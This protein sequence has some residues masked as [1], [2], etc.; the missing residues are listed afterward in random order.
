M[1]KKRT[2][3][4][5]FLERFQVTLAS[6]YFG[7]LYNRI[8]RPKNADPTDLITIYLK[9]RKWDYNEANKTVNASAFI[10]KPY[11]NRLETSVFNIKKMKEVQIWRLGHLWTVINPF[12]KNSGMK[13][14]KARGD[15][16]A[17]MVLKTATLQLQVD[18]SPHPRHHNILGWPS[19]QE[20]R[21]LVALELACNAKLECI[22]K[23]I[24]TK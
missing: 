13:N 20:S 6:L 7:V 17:A 22:P 23:Q 15:L 18:P 16:T 2:G 14:I 9:Q 24:Q 4:K 3:L 12:W 8:I 1:E 10:P 5:H 19:D 21:E 11:N